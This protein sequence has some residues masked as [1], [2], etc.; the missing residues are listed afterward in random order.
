MRTFGTH[1]LANCFC[2]NNWIQYS[3][4]YNA[5]DADGAGRVYGEC[6]RFGDFD[7]NWYAAN[8]TC[9]TKMAPGAF[10]AT[11]FSAHKN[12]FNNKYARDVWN[13]P[14][15]T[16]QYY[17]G[18][19]YVDSLKAYAWQ[20]PNGLPPTKVIVEV[21][22]EAA[23]W[24]LDHVRVQSRKCGS[25][26]RTRETNLSLRLCVSAMRQKQCRNFSDLVFGKN[27]KIWCFQ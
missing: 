6:L 27:W 25:L 24:L 2:K 20:Q 16:P 4:N 21:T 9:S 22:G 17:V 13:T 3:E 23:S 15:S 1:Y 12:R 5:T 26:R 18:L 19:S 11:E 7:S 10:L 14:G 8:R